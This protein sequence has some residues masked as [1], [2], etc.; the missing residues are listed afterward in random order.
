MIARRI[1][2]GDVRLLSIVLLTEVTL[3]VAL[4]LVPLPRLVRAI[5][6]CRAAA[7]RLAA[8]SEERIAW[9]VEGVGRRLPLLGTCLVRALA[10]DLLLGGREAACVRIGVRR[11][12]N[13]GLESHAWFERQGRIVVGGDGAGGYGDFTTLDTI[14]PER[15]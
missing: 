8:G 14:A 10:A 13:G 1:A 2:A 4:R 3:G 6:R 9:A 12:E 15:V 5:A 7:Q 11:D